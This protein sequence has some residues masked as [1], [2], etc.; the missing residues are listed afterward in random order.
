MATDK[1]LAEELIAHALQ[2][3]ALRRSKHLSAVLGAT[4]GQATLELVH[5][6]GST[7]VAALTAFG[8]PTIPFSDQCARLLPGAGRMETLAPAV[9][10]LRFDFRKGPLREIRIAARDVTEEVRAAHFIVAAIGE[11][12]VG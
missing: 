2:R 7:S 1:D 3:A 5:A 9:R 11:L 6:F 8:A 12:R 10:E 4:F